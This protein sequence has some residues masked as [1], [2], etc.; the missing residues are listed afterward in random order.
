MHD[1]SVPDRVFLAIQQQIELRGAICR[2][3]AMRTLLHSFGN[4]IIHPAKRGADTL[5]C[6]AE[7]HL[8]A[9][10]LFTGA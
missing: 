10:L 2:S 8:G 5:V 7:N 9:S 6:S 4:G 3:G 1:G